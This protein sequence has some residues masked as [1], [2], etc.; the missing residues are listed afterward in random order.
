MRSRALQTRRSRRILGLGISAIVAL[1]SSACI[2]EQPAPPGETN[3][4]TTVP[5][6]T[7]PETTVPDTTAP[8]TTS[9]TTA[10]PTTTA[11]PGGNAS[12]TITS[13][14]STLSSAPA[15]LTT[16]FQWQISD[17]EGAP[18]TCS[19][20]YESDGI[21]ETNVSN[22]TS[23]SLRSKTYSTMGSRTITLRVSDGVSTSRTA[24]VSVNVGA[25]SA[26][27][28]GITLRYTSGLTPSQQAAFTAAAA[29]WAAVI[30]TG[31]A[32]ATVNLAADW[33]GTGA[34]ALAGSVDDIHIDASIE[35]IDG[36]SG[37]LGQAGPCLTRA[38]NGL[39]IYGVMQFDSADIAALEAQG[40]LQTVILHE[41]GHV[42]GFGTVWNG[43]V[44]TGAGTSGVA[45]TGKVARG[46]WN[47]I[48]GS[49]LSVPVESTGG[50]GTA[51]SHWR[52]SVFHNEIMTGYLNSGFNPLSA[53]TIGSLADIG[54]GVDLAAAE[55][56][57]SATM[58]S[59]AYSVPID[60]SLQLL[61][62]LAS[63]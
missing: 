48:G 28:F 56:Y 37:I 5:E 21:Y 50:P 1:A 9:P 29:H 4:E 55:P 52:E 26:D 47:A 31:L 14:T 17:P 13:F 15:P 32:P 54:Y 49:G 25:A 38:A 3:P 23:A 30:K 16:A 46:A 19:L 41:M 44:L 12:P 57:G 8:A 6:T 35:P 24:T 33:C 60:F 62:P 63:Q 61:T 58:R 27:P 39:P 7:I 34:P 11:A 43:S 10:A 51:D 53:I 45:F 2:P 59:E 42:L 20:D 36:V 40:A 22:C 18:L